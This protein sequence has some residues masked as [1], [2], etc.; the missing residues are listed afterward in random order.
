MKAPLLIPP[1]LALVLAVAWNLA[2]IRSISSLEKERSTLREGISAA[3]KT[4][5]GGITTIHRPARQAKSST[6]KTNWN[7]ISTAFF[8]KDGSV[9]GMREL[10]EFKRRLANMT[11]LEMADALD[12]IA[13]QDMSAYGRRRL[14]WE[15]M[16]KLIEQEPGLALTRFTNHLG[17]RYGIGMALPDAF[18]NWA[19]TDPAAA[20]AWLDKQIA[21]GKFDRKSLDDLYD[22]RRVFEGMLMTRLLETDPALATQ[23]ILSLPDDQRAAVL[24]SIEVRNPSA[25]F[26]TA[27]GKFVRTLPADQQGECFAYVGHWMRPDLADSFSTAERFLDSAKATPAERTAALVAAGE[28][29]IKHFPNSPAYAIERIKEYYEAKAPEQADSMVGSALAGSTQSAWSGM[30]PFKD[31][32]RAAQQYFETSGNDDVLVAF[33]TRSAAASDPKI[34]EDYPLMIELAGKIQDDAQ[35]TQILKQLESSKNRP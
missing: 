19:K 5:S 25:E 29:R 2:Q 6:A 18:S 13:S 7:L 34:G 21:D 8:A 10:L 14:E 15:I 11:P 32:A 22:M 30:I 35:R 31:A 9:G 1:A 23:R 24:K 4:S 27:Y 16:K 28:M 3:M 26:S 33:L 20:T 12:E 17:E